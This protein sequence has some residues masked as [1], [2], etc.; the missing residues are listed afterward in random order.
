[1]AEW[2]QPI[3]KNMLTTR[4]SHQSQTE[5]EEIEKDISNKW[6]QQQ[7]AGVAILIAEKRLQTKN[8]N[9]RQEGL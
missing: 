2:K 1:M 3:S 5:N 8:G 6:K 4:D 9:K 7:K